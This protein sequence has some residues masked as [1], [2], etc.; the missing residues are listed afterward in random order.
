MPDT[1]SAE[2]APLPVQVA[3]VTS[4]RARLRV[5]TP[6]DAA[7]MQALAQRLATAPGV[8]RILARPMTGSVIVETRLPAADVLAEM[9]A[10]H[11]IRRQ[12]PVARPPVRQTVQLG[13]AQADFQIRKGTEAALDLKTA[14]ALLLL[15]A[16]LMQLARG[17][18]AGPATTLALGALSL[19]NAPQGGD[20]A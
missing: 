4:R 8:E 7:A 13:L 5:E 9:E 10:A 14:I 19:L 16:A 20:T 2:P 6:L 1:G 12:P 11:L 3:H 18:I 17:R 15:V